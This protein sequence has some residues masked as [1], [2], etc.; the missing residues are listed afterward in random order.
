MNSLL[1]YI[2][3]FQI[4][5]TKKPNELTEV[6][7]LLMKHIDRKTYKKISIVEIPSMSPVIRIIPKDTKNLK[8]YKILS[9]ACP[10]D[11]PDGCFESIVFEKDG[12]KE[13]ID[14]DTLNCYNSNE[15]GIKRLIEEIKKVLI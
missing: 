11:I 13:N 8:N 5:M 9:I 15:E 14:N 7:K 12:D 4:K 3:D 2:L 6:R 10:F 1:S